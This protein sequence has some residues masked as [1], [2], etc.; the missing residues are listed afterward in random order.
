MM[1]G[2]ITLFSNEYDK[3]SLNFLYRNQRNYQ[4]PNM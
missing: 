2:I 1:Q 3:F 4:W